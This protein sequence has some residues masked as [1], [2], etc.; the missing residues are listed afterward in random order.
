MH[1][2]LYISRIQN[3]G[4]FTA[5]ANLDII[6]SF[7]PYFMNMKGIGKAKQDIPPRILHAGP[8]PRF[9]NIGRTASGKAQARSERSSVFPAIALAAYG[10]Y[11]S[12]RK[13]RHC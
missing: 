6:L 4:S 2:D 8:T 10:P 3:Y 5:N 12:T 11:V 1:V 9:K 7:R 13:F